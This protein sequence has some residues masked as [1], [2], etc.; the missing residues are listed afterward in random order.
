MNEFGPQCIGGER[1]PSMLYSKETTGKTRIYKKFTSWKTHP[2][3]P[4]W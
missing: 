1:E 3:T 2:P 4:A